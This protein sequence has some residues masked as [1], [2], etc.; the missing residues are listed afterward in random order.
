MEKKKE[1]VAVTTTQYQDFSRE[2]TGQTKGNGCTT[3][4]F[5]RK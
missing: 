4:D 3:F 2:G 1:A 5:Q